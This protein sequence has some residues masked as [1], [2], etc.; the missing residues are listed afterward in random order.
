MYQ[1]GQAGQIQVLILAGILVI[2]AIAGGAYYLQ[3]KEGSLHFGTQKGGITPSPTPAASPTSTGA[4]ETANWKTYTNTKYSFS[5]KYPQNFSEESQ[6]KESPA[7]LQLSDGQRSIS[8]I[9]F[10]PKTSIQTPINAEEITIDGRPAKK[11]VQSEPNSQVNVHI[12]YGGY[13]YQVVMPINNETKT[14]DLVLFN[15]ILSTFRF[16]Q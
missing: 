6:G 3:S 16:T 8:F 15:Q 7:A 10:T 11:F 14:Q 5:L 9:I 13:L 4:D 2:A 1:K 12:N